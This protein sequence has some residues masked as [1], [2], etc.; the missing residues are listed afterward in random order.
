[1]LGSSA[2]RKGSLVIENSF[3]NPFGINEP[4]R[5]VCVA[6]AR[7]SEYDPEKC[8]PDT[9][10]SEVSLPPCD[11]GRRAW[12]CLLGAATI[13]GLMW[14]FPM[15]FGVFQSY[16]QTHPPFEKNQYIPVVGVLATGISYL[17]NP[18]ITPFVIK[19]QKYQ[20][21]MICLGWII[22]IIALLTSSF[23]TKVWHL[24]V[25]QGFL[26]GVGCVILY[27][28]VLSIVNEWFIKRR[29]LAYGL[30]F[31]SAGTC[32]LGLPFIIEKLLHNYGHATTLRAFAVG[33][34]LLIG[35][36][37]P[38]LQ[39]RLAP[40]NQ[41]PSTTF[42]TK[43][44]TNPLF[45]TAS[46]SNT[47]QGL[48]FFLPFLYL[49][50]YATSLG[51]TP[52][53]STL[54]LSLL[55]ASQIIGQIGIGYLSDHHNLYIPLFLS[56]FFSA[57][58]IF[59]LWGFAK[60]FGPL[61]VFS[62]LYG[63]FAGGY[64]VL[65]CRFATALTIDGDGVDRASQ[66]ATGLWLYSILEFQR[67][68][69]NIAGGVVSGIIVKR[70]V[71]EVA[72]GVGRYQWLVVLVGGCMLVSCLG[73]FGWFVKDKRLSWKRGKGAKNGVMG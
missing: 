17:G 19:H 65:Y 39:P 28:P 40:P 47:F 32:G 58:S 64:S 34:F 26:Y 5:S 38:L 55:S 71:V 72:Y 73:G 27:Y 9:N 48:A 21:H 36:V 12:A 46:F 31:G 51:L 29:G 20:R 10:I 62:I 8:L 56:P 67:G 54:P 22:C 44:F 25:T 59:M 68:V 1:M 69:G 66:R 42:N 35:P 45:Y 63:V 3:P 18:L 30:M 61:V 33:M 13:E 49:P 4:E 53:Q 24:M 41:T 52:T 57:L 11:G 23:A 7:T 6:S 2:T 43:V 60:S 37:L 14:G 50:S 15:T 16:F 70:E